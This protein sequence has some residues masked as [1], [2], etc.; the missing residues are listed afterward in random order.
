MR[1]EIKNWENSILKALTS[2]SEDSPNINNVQ[3]YP[4]IAKDGDKMILVQFLFHRSDS[5]Q[6]NVDPDGMLNDN[7]TNPRDNV[8]TGTFWGKTFF[9]KTNI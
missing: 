2:L 8:S 6:E 9:R 5:D 4:N 3:P 7:Q 1:D